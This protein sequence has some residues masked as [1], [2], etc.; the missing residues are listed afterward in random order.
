MPAEKK[1]IHPD[2]VVVAT[3]D[4]V[5]ADIGG[6]TILLHMKSAMYYGMEAVAARIWELVREPIRV[7]DIRDAI[8]DEY[9]VELD[10]CES[11]VLKFLRELAA[12]GLIKVTG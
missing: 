1:Q 8:A 9:E 6:E 2:A 3:R 12:K 5:S 11:D 7:S 10:Q 4:Q